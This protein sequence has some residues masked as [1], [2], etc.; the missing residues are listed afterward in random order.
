[1]LEPNLPPSAPAPRRAAAAQRPR[2]PGDA[3]KGGRRLAGLLTP[4]LVCLA[5]LA[6]G[7]ATLIDDPLSG[8]PAFPAPAAASAEPGGH[9]AG[10]PTSPATPLSFGTPIDPPVIAEAPAGVPDP[11]PDAL[12]D[13]RPE[14]LRATLDLSTR[15]IWDADA[16]EWATEQFVGLDLHKVFGDAEGDV[17]TLTVQGYLTR[18][19]NQPRR[20]PFFE[21][22]DDTVFVH[23]ILNLNVVLL[24]RGRLNLRVGHYELPFG[25][26]QPINTNGTLR[27]YSNAANLGVV[28]DW[29][30]TLNG[31]Q[32]RT[33]WEVGLS[34][35]SGNEL[36]LDG[37]SWALAGR[38][39]RLVSFDTSVGASAAVI[40]LAD[41]FN[42]VD[43]QTRWRVGVDGQR[44]L[45]P[46]TL[47]AEASVGADGDEQRLQVLGE[48]NWR[49]P[50]EALLAYG[51]VEWF[52]GERAAGGLDQTTSL[53]A[54]LR[55]L[56]TSKWTLSTAYT[57][58]IDAPGDRPRD[59]L[60][61]TQLRY[62]F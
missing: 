41:S 46:F 44:D 61:A 22:D 55:W 39:G 37:D 23:R 35:G 50:A 32:G 5:T 48:C 53:E 36:D 42:P 16:N 18:I 51:Q 20:A 31:Q 54:G 17:A 40:R 11:D 4:G 9:P 6:H 13:P 58:E 1:M 59:R 38:V 24:D 29:G 19:D 28:A 3:R 33:D 10:S 15:A 8:L 56:A 12:V 47:L 43:G 14:N 7:Q 34:R 2:L 27:Q 30:V 52:G 21:S 25:L 45:G 60:L 57:H 49:T 26:E 62:R